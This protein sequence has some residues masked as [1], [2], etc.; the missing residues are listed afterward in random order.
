MNNDFGIPTPN[1]N[2]VTL[3]DDE[4]M[5]VRAGRVLMS[6][7]TFKVSEFL[8]ALAQLVSDQEEDWSEEQEGWFSDRGTRC[9]VLRFGNQGWQRGRVRIRLEFCPEP[10]PKLLRESRSPR[11][12]IYQDESYRSEPRAERGSKR[13]PP[14]DDLYRRNSEQWNEDQPIY[15]ELDQD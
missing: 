7:P 1:E 12:D 4:V 2:F 10:P 6:N 14:R 15:P 11:E 5:F 8:D 13:R 3:S 9:E